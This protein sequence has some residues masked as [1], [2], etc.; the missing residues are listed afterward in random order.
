MAKG[1]FF[2]RYR[3][4]IHACCWLFSHFPMPIRRLMWSFLDLFS[5]NI[6]LGL[7]YCLLKTMAKSCGESVFIA[8]NVE[9]L[10]ANELEI[11]SGVSIHR[12]CYINA[13]GGIR[14][15][16][17]VSIAHASTLI[18]SNHTWGNPDLPIRR[19]PLSSAPITIHDD[20]WIGCGVRIL[21]GVEVGSRT[22][23]AAGA[24]VNRNLEPY[25]VY[26][27]IPAKRIKSLTL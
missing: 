8:Q 14:I 25:G 15:G 2:E 17:E 10:G 23:I 3:K 4:A 11:G 20:V 26:G 12:F 19:N 6:A 7:R 16:N 24:V 27:G 9:I 5:G 22:V 21:A 13:S 1:R 18:A